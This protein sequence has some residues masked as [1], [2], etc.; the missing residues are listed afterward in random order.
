VNPFEQPAP[1]ILDHLPVYAQASFFSQYLRQSYGDLAREL[2]ERL[3]AF[4]DGEGAVDVAWFSPKFFDLAVLAMDTKRMWLSILDNDVCNGNQQYKNALLDWRDLAPKHFVPED[5]EERWETEEGPVTVSFALKGRHVV[6]CPKYQRDWFDIDI[7]ND[8]ND[9]IADSPVQF[10]AA[11][12]DSNVFVCA[13]T[14]VQF[15]KLCTLVDAS[16]WVVQ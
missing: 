3:P 5:I 15:T 14:E 12:M 2:T 7:L 10:Y 6:T 4:W 13:L 16:V 9:F 8:I 1:V 11:L